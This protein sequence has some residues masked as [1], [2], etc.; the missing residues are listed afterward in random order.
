[1]YAQ[2]ADAVRV[3]GPQKTW[4]AQQYI[5]KSETGS[6]RNEPA[7]VSAFEMQY[8]WCGIFPLEGIPFLAIAYVTRMV[9]A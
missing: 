5:S 4:A 9:L 2:E 6:T 8:S 3:A 7:L 1:M